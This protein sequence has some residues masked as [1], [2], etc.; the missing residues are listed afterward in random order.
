M[1]VYKYMYKQINAYLPVC[2]RSV[3]FVLIPHGP[4][5]RSPAVYRCQDYNVVTE[6][7]YASQC[8]VTLSTDTQCQLD[9]SVEHISPPVRQLPLYVR[10]KCIVFKPLLRL[11]LKPPTL[12]HYLNPSYRMQI[13][14]DRV[15]AHT[16]GHRMCAGKALF[17]I[18][19]K[20]ITETQTH[21]QIDLLIFIS[22]SSVRRANT[23]MM[24]L[25]S[26]RNWMRRSDS[27][28]LP[29]NKHRVLISAE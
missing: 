8:H 22:S 13:H 12:F 14:G 16:Q 24:A 3:R 25:K 6:S 28:E 19:E 1:C 26:L 29:A 17:A 5:C 7:N 10:Q 2:E 9:T 4:I 20:K 15:Q 21:H 23:M 18:E 27:D 11:F